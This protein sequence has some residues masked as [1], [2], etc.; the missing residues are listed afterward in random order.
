MAIV[1]FENGWINVRDWASSY[2]TDST[3]S[4]EGDLNQTP[5]SGPRQSSDSI[6]P[7]PGSVSSGAVSGSG[8]GNSNPAE[9]VSYWPEIEADYGIP[10]KLVNITMSESGQAVDGYSIYLPK[11]FAETRGGYPVLMCLQ[12]GSSVGGELSRVN[13]WGVPLHLQKNYPLGSRLGQYLQDTFIIISPHIRR[14]EYYDEAH[15]IHEILNDTIEQYRGDPSKIYITGLS[16]GGTGVWGL[17]SSMPDVFAAAVPVGGR[18][19]GIHNPSDLQS[20]SLWVVHNAADDVVPFQPVAN[21][22]SRLENIT[23]FNSSP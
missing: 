14:G 22:I 8:S 18:T 11:S 16:R 1:A 2:L 10:G 19:D 4:E 21:V 12:G 13:Q 17:A 6:K 3:V 15:A 23:D 20:I 9:S 5:P 7:A